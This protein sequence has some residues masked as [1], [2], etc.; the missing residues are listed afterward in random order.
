MNISSESKVIFSIATLLTHLV[1]TGWAGFQIFSSFQFRS[2]FAEVTTNGACYPINLLP[3][4]WQSRSAA[5]IPSFVLNAVALLVSALLSWRLA[6]VRFFPSCLKSSEVD[7][8]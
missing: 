5:E 4:Y 1:A 8:H 6:K 7:S 2:D 3:T